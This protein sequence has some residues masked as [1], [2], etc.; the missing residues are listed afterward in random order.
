[1]ENAFRL[2][3]NIILLQDLCK[4]RDA[5]H[6]FGIGIRTGYEIDSAHAVLLD[7]MTCDLLHCRTVV[8]AD[9]LEIAQLSVNADR[10]NA[11]LPDPRIQ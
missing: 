9:I 3:R 10:R 2:N 1:M 6:V 4:G 7:H 11:G 5:L 8:D